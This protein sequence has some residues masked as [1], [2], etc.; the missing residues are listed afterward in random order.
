[1]R[2]LILLVVG[3]VAAAACGDDDGGTPPS[4]TGV[5]EITTTTTGDP[6]TDFTVIVDGASPRTIAANG[7]LT[8]P[9]VE[10]GS[11]IVQLTLPTG[12]TL[13]GENPQ[14]VGVTEDV[15][16][17]VAFAVTCGAG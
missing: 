6:G 7:T 17:P 11:H 16:A 15:A 14:T 1:M 13:E 9:G 10:V 5:I 3:L 4:A 8:I 2:R 12:C